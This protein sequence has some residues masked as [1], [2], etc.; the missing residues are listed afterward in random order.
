MLQ[1]ATNH[2]LENDMLLGHN[3]EF[4][5][6]GAECMAWPSQYQG[7]AISNSSGLLGESLASQGH[8][9]VHLQYQCVGRPSTAVRHL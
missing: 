9:C 6:H 2:Q 3:A 7:E 5:A 8:E 1:G 4:A